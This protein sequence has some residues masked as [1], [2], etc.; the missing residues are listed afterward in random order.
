M[1]LARDRTPSAPSRLTGPVRPL[2]LRPRIAPGVLLSGERLF[3]ATAAG[4]GAYQLR[5][6]SRTSTARGFLHYG[7]GEGRWKARSTR[8]TRYGSP[9]T[10]VRSRQLGANRGN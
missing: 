10:A 6:K 4:S 8:S 7:S 3:I 5:G 2:V 1:R 9:G